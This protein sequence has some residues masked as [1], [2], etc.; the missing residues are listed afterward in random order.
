MGRGL[1]GIFR[2][3]LFEGEATSGYVPDILLFGQRTINAVELN[4]NAVV[5]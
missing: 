1:G 5:F 3:V 2:H 4:L